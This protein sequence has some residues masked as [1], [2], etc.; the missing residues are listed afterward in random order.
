MLTIMT[1]RAEVKTIM[2]L[3]LSSL[4]GDSQHKRSHQKNHSVIQFDNLVHKIDFSN[5]RNTHTNAKY[6]KNY[7]LI[8][9][10]TETQ[11]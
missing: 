8:H 7:L 6:I 3:N 5:D 2:R 9:V 11:I 1:W 10:Q 4:K